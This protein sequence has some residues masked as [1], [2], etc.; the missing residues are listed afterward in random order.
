MGY[1]VYVGSNVAYVGRLG[2]YVVGEV[3]SIDARY[4]KIRHESY[5]GY[6]DTIVSVATSDVYVLASLNQMVRD[7]SDLEKNPIMK[8]QICR[9]N[10]RY[11]DV[12]DREEALKNQAKSLTERENRIA[13]REDDLTERSAELYEREKAL[14]LQDI[15]ETSGC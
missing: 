4:T 9:L 5:D 10:D 15:K 3:L 13:E 11:T 12:T 6:D 1:D 8:R 7:E 14:E 2:D